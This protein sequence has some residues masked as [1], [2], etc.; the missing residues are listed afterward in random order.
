MIQIYHATIPSY[1]SEW[2]RF[3]M[4]EISDKN[5]ML[6][7]PAGYGIQ[8]SNWSAN[9]LKLLHSVEAKHTKL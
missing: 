4:D 1:E 5:T 2:T 7:Y 8:K 6:V 9:K 3:V